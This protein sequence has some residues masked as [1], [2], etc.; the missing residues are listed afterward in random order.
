MKDD[1]SRNE[2]EDV[3]AS[4]QATEIENKELPNFQQYLP[5]LSSSNTVKPKQTIKKRKTASK[6][7]TNETDY[8]SKGK[9]RKANGEENVTNADSGDGLR[10]KN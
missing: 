5:S 10:L 7:A 2:S 4:E 8:K 6:F 1:E 9:K 3:H